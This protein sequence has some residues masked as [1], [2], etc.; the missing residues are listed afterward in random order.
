MKNET[1]I[2]AEDVAIKLIS[3]GFTE[4]DTD[5]KGTR[6][7]SRQTIVGAPPDADGDKVFIFASIGAD[8]LCAMVTTSPTPHGW[9]N[10]EY[11]DVDPIFFHR[12]MKTMERQVIGAWRE[13]AD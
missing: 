13:L 1:P 5:E 8:G 6:H 11:T 4:V 3:T 9:A 10:V 2:S 7:F 12:N